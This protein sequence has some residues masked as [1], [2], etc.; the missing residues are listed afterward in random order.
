MAGVRS[1]PPLPLS[2][3]HRPSTQARR[4]QLAPPVLS[5]LRLCSPHRS[6]GA[7]EFK[8]NVRREFAKLISLLQAYAVISTGV[9]FIATNQVAFAATTL[10]ACTAC[11]C[12]SC[13]P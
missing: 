8:R 5:A 2:K 1:P 7:Q 11:V 9:R 12:P 3:L 4:Q 10:E 13:A 6:Y